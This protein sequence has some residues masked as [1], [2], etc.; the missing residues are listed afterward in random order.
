MEAYL[1]MRKENQS[2]PSETLEFM[3]NTALAE[4]EKSKVKNL[5][6]HGVSSALPKK[7][8]KTT[9]EIAERFYKKGDMMYAVKIL[10]VNTSMTLKECKEYADSNYC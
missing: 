2:V 6:M 4:L 7:P 8:C 10:S 1:F 9:S 3:K 5:P